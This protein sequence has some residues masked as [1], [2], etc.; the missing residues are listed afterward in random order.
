MPKTMPPSIHEVYSKSLKAHFKEKGKKTKNI[1]YPYFE[2]SQSMKLTRELG[3]I[4][5]ETLDQD[6]KLHTKEFFNL[7]I[8]NSSL[9]NANK[10]LF[11]H[12]VQNI[13]KR[14][15]FPSLFMDFTHEGPMPPKKSFHNQAGEN[16]RHPKDGKEQMPKNP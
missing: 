9:S 8:D 14:G 1:P 11:F 5:S 13:Y 12:I 16:P 7:W 4:S 10:F 3:L 15:Y 6:H 2:F